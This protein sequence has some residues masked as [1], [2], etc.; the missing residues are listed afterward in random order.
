MKKGLLTVCVAVLMLLLLSSCS[1]DNDEI[2]GPSKEDPGLDRETRSGT[3]ELPEDTTI[4]FNGLEVVTFAG[5]SDV[6]EDGAFAVPSPKADNYQI[7]FF[8]SKSTRNPIYLGLYNPLN[9]QVQSN[10]SSTALCLAL[11]NPMLIYSDVSKRSVYLDAVREHNR[12]PDLLQMLYIAYADNAET[13]L[14][15]DTNPVM[16][17]LLVQI[18]REVLEQ[19]GNHRGGNPLDLDPPQILEADGTN[20]IFSNPRH[21][22][23][24]AGIHPKDGNQTDIV[25]IDRVSTSLSFEWGFPPKIE[26]TEP[27]ETIYDLGNGEFDIKIAGGYDFTK[28][29]QWN[30][31][32]GRATLLNTGQSMLYM[33]EL[34]IGQMPTSQLSGLGGHIGITPS[35]AAEINVSLDQGNS[36][37]LLAAFCGLVE[38]NSQGIVDWIWQESMTNASREYIEIGARLTAK[39]ALA[40][41]LLGFT[42]SQSHFFLDMIY[43]PKEIIYHITQTNGEITTPT[44]NYPPEARFR[45]TPPAGIVGTNFVFDASISTDDNDSIEQLSFRWDWESNGVWDTGWIEGDPV[46]S[47]IYNEPGAYQVTLE[48]RDSGM[49]TSRTARTLNVGGGAGTA[50]RVK[51]FRDNLPWSTNAMVNMLEALGFTEGEGEYTYEVIS[52]DMFATVPLIPGEDLVIIS[53]DQNQTFYNNYAASQLRFTNFVLNGGSLFWEACDEGWAGGSM[54]EA[55]V[56][57]PGNVTATLS[58]DRNNFVTDQ[59]LPLV[60]GLP[61]ELEHNYAS[62]ENFTN[63]PDGTTVYMVDSENKAT[64]IEFNIGLGWIII[65]GQP[66]EHQ[67]VYSSSGMEELLERIVSHFTGKTVEDERGVRPE[68]LLPLKDSKGT[69]IH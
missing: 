24:S 58:F 17:Q 62:H 31:P 65:T 40:L 20:I 3:L 51:L 64:L 36:Q 37:G 49:L 47:H 61:D 41:R 28:I 30:N 68:P 10:V 2:L 38:D 23:Y 48:V 63:L 13:A 44:I 53:N 18:I 39:L 8:V 33:M 32:T 67:Y 9:V 11:I 42:D 56:I 35:R 21:I 1:D 26:I 29:S 5:S 14:D 50:N 54:A 66:L 27:Q 22:W 52:S 34:L 69:I 60:S 55:G 4:G 19:L 46:I 6:G 45:I 57:L 7:I 15:Y 43:A 25:T 59:N 16:Y 12:F